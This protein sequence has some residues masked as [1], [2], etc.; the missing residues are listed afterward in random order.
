MGTDPGGFL[1]IVAGGF[2]GGSYFL[3]LKWAKPWAWENI[4]LA[5]S[6]F[7]LIVLPV[8]MVLIN[9]PNPVGA[10]ALVPGRAAATV[11]LLGMG[12]GVGA[13]LSGLGVDRV[14]VGLGVSLLVGTAASCGALIP[15]MVH[16]P[17][18]IFRPKG[19][20][21]ILSVVILSGGVAL[22]GI[23]GKKRDVAQ[24]AQQRARQPG[25]YVAGLLICIFGGILSAMLNLAFSFSDPLAEAAHRVGASRTG[26][27]NFVWMVALAGGLL[28]NAAY[29]IFLLG[30]HR[31]WKNFTYQG[32]GR[33]M[34]VGILMALFWYFG[35]VCYGHGASVLG[36]LGTIV[37]WP[38][39]VS[40]MMIF[41][42]I[43]GFAL[44]EWNQASREARRYML[45]GLLVLVLASG[46]SVVSKIM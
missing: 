28:F 40:S 8:A 34:V 37:G 27:E 3:G 21:V 15:L 35:A 20:V 2:M 26:A 29:T 1:L 42:T 22:V 14:G 6:V 7:A 30:R 32:S 19:L 41:S 4:W 12:W 24:A 18:L 45:A 38:V 39:F 31:T 36:K 9:V 23:A 25:G 16:S 13:A 33:S 46:F 43:W 44:G 11:F 10:L 17:E 5:Y